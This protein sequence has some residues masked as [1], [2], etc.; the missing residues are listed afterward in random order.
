MNGCSGSIVISRRT[1]PIHDTDLASSKAT[2]ITG[3]VEYG[4]ALSSGVQFSFVE[5]TRRTVF[6]TYEHA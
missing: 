5:A 1:F 3:P 6:T 2:R 4:H